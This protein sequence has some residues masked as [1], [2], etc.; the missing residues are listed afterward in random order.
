M[1]HGFPDRPLEREEIVEG[2]N[3]RSPKKKRDEG[4]F[5]VTGSFFAVFKT[6]LVFSCG[7]VGLCNVCHDF[8][9]CG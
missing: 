4:S 3:C 2:Q 7:S 5:E 8:F 1:G 9:L 6:S